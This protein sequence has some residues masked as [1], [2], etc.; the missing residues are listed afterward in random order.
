MIIYNRELEQIEDLETQ[1]KIEQII[2]K[3]VDFLVSNYGMDRQMIE[4]KL[5]DLSIV[6]Y[7]KRNDK[8]YFKKINGEIKEF[9]IRR[10]SSSILW[11][12][13]AKLY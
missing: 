7:S 11:A 3:Q 9:S 2:K 5:R 4:N 6:E 12:N 13:R 10:R 1:S 8:T